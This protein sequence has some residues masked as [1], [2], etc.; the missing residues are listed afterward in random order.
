MREVC[1][2]TQLYSSVVS[3]IFKS[4]LSSIKL[5]VAF[6]FWS[7]IPQLSVLND[8]CGIHKHITLKLL[9][10]VCQCYNITQLSTSQCKAILIPWIK[11]R[12]KRPHKQPA[13]KLVKREQN[14]LLC[15]IPPK[16]PTSNIL[17]LKTHEIVFVIN[18]KASNLSRPPQW[19]VLMAPST[20]QVLQ[21]LCW[22]IESF[23]AL[24][25]VS[26]KSS[27][28][29]PIPMP[30]G[31]ASPDSSSNNFLNSQNLSLLKFRVL[32]Q[33]IGRPTF[34]EITNS[35]KAW[36]LQSK[37]PL[38]VISLMISSALVSTRSRKTSV[39]NMHFTRMCWKCLQ[40]CNLLNFL[41][42]NED[43]KNLAIL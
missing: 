7:V 19:P 16:M 23:Y 21:A 8:L 9:H 39:T 31:R 43:L 3:Y 40:E 29:Y 41:S 26:F 12:L 1:E 42:F 22:G 37:L 5:Q 36:S 34:L 14:W 35:T 38:I 30:L 25:K 20:R 11:K 15:T 24:R 2:T 27:Q 10:Q 28:L 33:H 32:T 6:I 17:I 13:L 4:V 18:I